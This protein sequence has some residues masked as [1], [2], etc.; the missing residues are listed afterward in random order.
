MESQFARLLGCEASSRANCMGLADSATVD[1]TDVCQRAAYP[2]PDATR[3]RI[4]IGAM[5]CTGNRSAARLHRQGARTMT[6]PR[7][8]TAKAAT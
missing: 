2:R 5:H 4:S 8:G 7:R 1:D 3:S 6:S